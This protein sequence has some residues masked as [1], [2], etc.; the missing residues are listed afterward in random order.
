[1]AG[2]R[3]FSVHSAK[4]RDPAQRRA[5]RERRTIAD[6]VE[7]AR[8]AYETRATGREAPGSFSARLSTH[9][10]TAIEL[11]TVIREARRVDPGRGL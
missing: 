5:R 7:R 1:M 2:P 11:E 10:G 6:I 4:A 9:C 3:L 8:E